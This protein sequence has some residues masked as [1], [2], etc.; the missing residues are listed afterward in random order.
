MVFRFGPGCVIALLSLTACTHYQASGP[1][2]EK[3]LT[4]ESNSAPAIGAVDSGSD[5]HST[6]TQ[7]TGAVGSG[8]DVESTATQAADSI[9]DYIP[10]ACT[11]ICEPDFWECRCAFALKSG[12]KPECTNEFAVDHGTKCD[13]ETIDECLGVVLNRATARYDKQLAEATTLA[14]DCLRATR[15]E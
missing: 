6:V 5:V 1:A 13:V 2:F 4:V 11:S 15:G 7:A 3:T 14:L 12:I 9:E 8:S 10:K